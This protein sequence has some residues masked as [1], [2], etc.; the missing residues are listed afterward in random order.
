MWHSF[1]DKIYVISLDHAKTENLR[2][3]LAKQ[4]LTRFGIPFEFYSAVYHDD[5]AYGCYLTYKQIFNLCI[6]SGYKNVLILE[7]DIKIVR[8]DFLFRIETAIMN[9][10]NEYH[11]FHLGP[12][13]HCPLQ[14][15]EKYTLLKMNQCRSTHAQAYSQ[16]AMKQIL[17]Y[18]WNGIPIDQMIEEKLQPLGKCYCTYPLLVTQRNGFSDIDKK[19]V[20][21]YYIEE[22][23]SLNTKHLI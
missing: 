5:G 16:E 21:M 9:L 7:D 12:N 14:W 22:R 19:E 3:H 8:D 23:F 1:F 4:E 13:T 2:S 15:H 10:P 20:N 6:N 17:T 11:T 18:E